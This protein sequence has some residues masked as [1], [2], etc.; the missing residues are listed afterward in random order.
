MRKIIKHKSASEPTDLVSP[1][2]ET[3]LTGLVNKMCEQLVALEK[4]VDSLI[5]RS[6]D[7]PQGG[8]RFQ[9]PSGPRFRPDDRSREKNFTQ[10]ICSQCGKECE[11]PFKPSGDRPVYCRDCFSA[12]NDSGPSRGKFGDRPKE[13]GFSRGRSFDGR[14]QAKGP[15][16]GKKRGSFFQRRKERS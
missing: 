1:Q 7:R 16:F 12:R 15:R 6:L 10:A 5:N 14:S 2:A 11:L 13:G 9:R 8:D 3:D 4:K